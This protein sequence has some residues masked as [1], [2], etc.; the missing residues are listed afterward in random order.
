MKTKKP[1]ITSGINLTDALE[2]AR[3]LGFTIEPVRRTGEQRMTHPAFAK[4][5]TFNA[6]RKDAPREITQA[7]RRIAKAS[8][9]SYTREVA[10]VGGA[11]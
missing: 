6:R 7:I 11:K 1:S 5:V 4:P 8:V 2:I 10:D 3:G 9:S